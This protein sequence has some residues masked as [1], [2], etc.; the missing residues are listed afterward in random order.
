MTDWN[1]LIK[2]TDNDVLNSLILIG[3]V[4]TGVQMCLSVVVTIFSL[5][6]TLLIWLHDSLTR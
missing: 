3:L 6:T 5:V 1:L 2:I 4:G